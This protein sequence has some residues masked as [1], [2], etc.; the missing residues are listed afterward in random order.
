MIKTEGSF[1][2]GFGVPLKGGRAIK[3]VPYQ[4][5]YQEMNVTKVLEFN[6]TLLQYE[7]REKAGETYT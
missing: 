6:Q 4:P 1:G 3:D 7:D 5:L 2:F